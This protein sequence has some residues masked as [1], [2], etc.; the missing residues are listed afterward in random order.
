MTSGSGGDP[1]QLRAERDSLQTRLD[2]E[3]LD[4]S[5]RER[6][7][8]RIAELDEQLGGGMQADAGQHAFW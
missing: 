2:S 8:N 6:V 5:E 3:E 4:A 1:Q 7:T